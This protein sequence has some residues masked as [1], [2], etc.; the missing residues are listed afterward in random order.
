M[1]ETNIAT[2]S[3]CNKSHLVLKFYVLALLKLKET[4]NSKALKK[5]ATHAHKHISLDCKKTQL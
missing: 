3:T 1:T 5:S 2:S 4:K